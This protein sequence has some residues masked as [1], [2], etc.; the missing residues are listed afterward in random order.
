MPCSSGTPSSSASGFFVFDIFVASALCD[1]KISQG[2][3]ASMALCLQQGIAWFVPR[4]GDIFTL[5]SFVVSVVLASGCRR[6]WALLRCRVYSVYSST[7]LCRD[8]RCFQQCACS[9]CINVLTRIQ[10]IN[11]L[12]PQM[13]FC[14]IMQCPHRVPGATRLPGWRF[15]VCLGTWAS[16]GHARPRRKLPGAATRRLGS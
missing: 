1:K 6:N 15:F 16:C 2:L 10:S 9:K 3:R 14:S 8:G 12:L 11:I 5:T 4:L 13:L 7:N